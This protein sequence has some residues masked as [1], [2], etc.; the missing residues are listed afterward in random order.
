MGGPFATAEGVTDPQVTRVRAGHPLLAGVDLSGATFGPTPNFTLGAGDE[1]I[2]GSADGPLLF[3]TQVNDQ[4]AVVLTVDP[5][6][7]NLPK[8]VAFPVLVANMIEAL[9]PDGIPAAIP[10]GEPLVY[11]PRASTVSVEVVTPSGETAQLPVFSAEPRGDQ[12]EGDITT[13]P[14][15]R[16]RSSRASRR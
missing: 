6:T 12:D 13:R 7:S 4:P 10:L 1:E 9:A 15:S 2:I 3:H 16:R 5:E 11:E 8:R 14:V